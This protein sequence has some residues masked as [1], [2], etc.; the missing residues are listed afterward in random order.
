MLKLKDIYNLGICIFELMIGRFA[1]KRHSISLDNVPLTW[2]EFAD[3]GPLISV[4]NECLILD[5][6]SVSKGKLTTIRDI[7]IS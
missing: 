2:A 5:G 1:R 7:L 6:K 4:M 3:T